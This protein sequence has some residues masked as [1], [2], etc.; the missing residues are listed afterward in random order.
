MSRKSIANK[1]DKNVAISPTKRGTI[2]NE[3]LSKEKKNSTIAA[4]EIA[5]IPRRKEYL[6][7]SCR[8]QPKIRAVEIVMPDLETPGTIANA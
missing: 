7:A 6:A 1:E 3:D 8:F 4:S 5:G 2:L